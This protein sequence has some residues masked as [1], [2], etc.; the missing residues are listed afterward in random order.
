MTRSIKELLPVVEVK[1]EQF[2]ANCKAEA[3]DIIVT[4]TYRSLE[5]QNAEYA[6]G[7]TIDIDKPIVTHAKGGQSLHNWGVAFDICPVV[8]GKV[9]YDDNILWEKIARIGKELGL[10]WGGDW[11]IFP[12]KPHFQYTLGYTWQDFLA[13]TVDLT[14]FNIKTNMENTTEGQFVPGINHADDIVHDNAV[15]RQLVNKHN[16]KIHK[17]LATTFGEEEV[18]FTTDVGDIVFSNIGKQGNLLNDNYTE[19]IIHD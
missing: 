10:E 19:E 3:I 8:R 18:I 2:I 13:G 17:V 6:I 7:R 4:G 1:C 11:T 9:V 12:D 14:K 16:G 5:E 15:Q